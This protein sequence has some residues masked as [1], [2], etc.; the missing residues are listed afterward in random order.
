M[1]SY[2]SKTGKR[3][4]ACI[5]LQMLDNFIFIIE[6]LIF[7]HGSLVNYDKP[8]HTGQRCSISAL[9]LNFEVQHLLPSCERSISS[10]QMPK[11]QQNFSCSF[12]VAWSDRSLPLNGPG[13]PDTR[14]C[15]RR[16]WAHKYF[17]FSPSF[18]E[19]FLFLCENWSIFSS[20]PSRSKFH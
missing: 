9:G 5:E 19:R 8:R 18:K 20:A 10:T 6:Q 17:R 12:I 15:L 11:M 1:E 3:F 14:P 4:A 7:H 2:A 16:G 13:N